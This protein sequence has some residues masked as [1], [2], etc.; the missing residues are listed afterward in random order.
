VRRKRPLS[1]AGSTQAGLLPT[2]KTAASAPAP[3]GHLF[4]RFNGKLT[5]PFLIFAAKMDPGLQDEAFRTG[6]R[7]GPAVFEAV[8]PR[9]GCAVIKAHHQ[10]GRETDVPGAA[11]DDTHQ[12]G[13]PN[14]RPHEIG[15]NGGSGLGVKFGFKYERSRPIAPSNAAGRVLWRNQPTAVFGRAQQ[16]GETAGESKRGQHSQSTEPLRPT[17]AAV[18]E[19]PISA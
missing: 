12:V 5:D 16:G 7:V 15:K 19:S 14:T 2:D 18:L 13:A 6:D 4:T 3:E 1:C 11:G 17:K 9:H 8:G 10:F